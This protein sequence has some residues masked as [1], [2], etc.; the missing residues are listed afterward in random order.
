MFVSLLHQA[1]LVIL[2]LGQLTYAAIPIP[3]YPQGKYV[4]LLAGGVIGGFYEGAGAGLTDAEFAQLAKNAMIDA[5]TTAQRWNKL[6]PKTVAVYI[7]E[8]N[9]II[10]GASG[11]GTGKHAEYNVQQIC[12]D[13]N[14]PFNG[15]RIVSW[16]N[17]SRRFIPACKEEANNSF[18]PFCERLLQEH[19]GIQDQQA[20]FQQSYPRRSVDNKVAMDFDA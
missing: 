4:A 6:Q 9:D 7:N 2:L 3:M 17:T 12:S 19:G 11:G 16:N 8:N 20:L 10:I 14:T 18:N 15:G 5:I 1:W 13:K